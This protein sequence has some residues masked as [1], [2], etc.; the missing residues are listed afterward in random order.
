MVAHRINKEVADKVLK[1]LREG[2]IARRIAQ[3]LG[4]SPGVVYRIRDENQIEKKTKT[5][6]FIVRQQAKG[7]FPHTGRLSGLENLEPAVLTWLASKSKRGETFAQVLL[8]IAK[9]RFIEEEL[10]ALWAIALLFKSKR[11]SGHS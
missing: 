2:K 8:A 6:P 3:D 9:E 11:T 7:A 4:I 1:A 5:T 10:E